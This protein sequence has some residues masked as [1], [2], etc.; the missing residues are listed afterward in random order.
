MKKIFLALALLT[1]SLAGVAQESMF[2]D[3][4]RKGRLPKS[5][6]SATNDKGSGMTIQKAETYAQKNI[7]ERS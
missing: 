1:V 6:Y 7:P 4:L 3:G 2:K 5:F